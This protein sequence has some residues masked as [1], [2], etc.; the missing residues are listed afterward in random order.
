M[1][2]EIYL[3]ID[4]GGTKVAA[5]LVDVNGTILYK[6]RVPMNGTGTA[7][8]GFAAVRRAIDNTLRENPGVNVTAVGAASPGPLDP[9]T[10]VI[11]FAPN[12]PCWRNFRLRDAIAE[13]YKL[14]TRVDNDANAAGL[15]EAI[16]GAGRG[17]QSVFYATLGTGIGTAIVLAGRLYYGRTGLAAEGGHQTIDRNAEC[18]CKCGKRGCIE[19]MASGTGIGRRAR[20]AVE[21][22][23]RAGAKILEL[24]DGDLRSI[25]GRVVSEAWRAGD[26]LAGEILENTATTLSV[27]L[28]N[29]VDLLEP[30]V[31]VVGGGMSEVFSHYFGHIRL[32]LPRWSV[33]ERS[34]EIPIIRAH[35]GEDSGIAGAAALC[36]SQTAATV[37]GR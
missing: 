34:G 7:E 24:A 6:T 2:N 20:A 3:G 1:S 15:A 36:L 18:L 4:I 17:Y 13:A 10:G 25:N 8:E 19:S 23:A 29:I 9:H 37:N 11:L 33:N 30:D 5:G 27:W 21:K 26:P 14:P 32:Q 28:G 31:I 16:W 12:V 22:D 35:Y